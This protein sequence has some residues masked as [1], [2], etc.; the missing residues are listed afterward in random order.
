MACEEVVVC[1][2]VFVANSILLRLQG[3][4][5]ECQSVL[6]ITWLLCENL[7]NVS[8]PVRGCWSHLQFHYTINE[9]KRKSAVVKEAMSGIHGASRCQRAWPM[10]FQATHNSLSLVGKHLTCVEG[11]PVWPRCL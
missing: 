10:V 8:F 3:K 9:K 7:L 1:C 2:D 4:D 5:T 11:F 6:L